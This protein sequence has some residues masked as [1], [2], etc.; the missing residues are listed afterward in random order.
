MRCTG[1]CEY[2]EVCKGAFIKLL[3]PECYGQRI[4]PYNIEKTL[5]HELL[6]IKFC[7]L[8]DS[9][10]PLQDRIVHQLIDEFANILVDNKK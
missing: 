2:N 3:R 5:V 8:D 6:H 10:N 1:E 7:L 9:G 4:I